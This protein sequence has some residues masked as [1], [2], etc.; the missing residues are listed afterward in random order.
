M[1]SSLVAATLTLLILPLSVPA[2]GAPLEGATC[3][4]GRVNQID[5]SG[6]LGKVGTIKELYEAGWRVAAMAP[7]QTGYY[8]VVEQQAQAVQGTASQTL[9]GPTK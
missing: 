6:P 4:P 3:W 9:S 7:S 1:K 5:C 8:F 2:L